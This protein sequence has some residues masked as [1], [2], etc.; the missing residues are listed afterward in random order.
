MQQ[1]SLRGGVKTRHREAAVA[2]KSGNH[3]GLP[4][5]LAMSLF[6]SWALAAERSVSVT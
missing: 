3:S 1:K 6:D 2:W 5:R 4:D